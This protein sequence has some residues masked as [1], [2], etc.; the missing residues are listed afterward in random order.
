MR[1]R[2]PSATGF[3]PLVSRFTQV[4]LGLLLLPVLAFAQ[5]PKMPFNP[6]Q[7]VCYRTGSP[8]SIDGK[9]SGEAWDQVHWTKDFVDIEGDRKPRPKFRTRTK[10]LWDEQYFYI[11]AELEEPDIWA[12]LTERESVIFHDNDFEVFIDPTGDTH[13]YYEFEVNA[14]GTEWDLL[15]P[16]PYRDG[17]PAINSWDI[18]GLKVGIHIDGTLNDPA[19]K[20]RKW[21]VEMAFPWAVLKEAAP[22]HRAPRAGEQWRVNFSRVQWQTEVVNGKYVKKKDP[23]TKKPFP[24]DNWVWS[25]QGVVN[26]HQPETWG[27]VQFSDRRAGA[28]TEAFVPAPDEEVKWALRQLYYAQHR[29]HKQHQR[30]TDKLAELD[31]TKVPIPGYVFAPEIQCTR[32]LFEITAKSRSGPHTWHIRQDGLIWR[33]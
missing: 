32:N 13:N 23:A 11:A 31:Y 20:D 4:G 29:H 25:P 1:T 24:E 27:F 18:K 17:G 22:G 21:T 26:M 6:E 12:T 30:F 9:L 14:L 10:M 5:E 15:L 16:K 8:L 33:E 2:F 7:Y 28:G 19:T 3:H